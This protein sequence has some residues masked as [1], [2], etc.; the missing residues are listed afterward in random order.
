MK[1]ISI[2]EKIKKERT[3]TGESQENIGK[4][5]LISQIESGQISN[6]KKETLIEIATNL[7]ISFDELIDGTNWI[8]PNQVSASNGLVFSQRGLD[9]K[10][11]SKGQIY[12]KRRVFH[13]K[14]EK[15][16]VNNYCPITGEKL[17]Q[18]CD[19]CEREFEKIDQL[20][21]MGCGKSIF[22]H[23]AIDEE[24]LDILDEINSNI[25]ITNTEAVNYTKVI[26]NIIKRL[27]IFQRL[28]DEAQYPFIEKQ[29]FSNDI[30]ENLSK[31]ESVK[32][33]E[34][35]K[36]KKNSIF[37]QYDVITQDYYDNFISEN[38]YSFKG[39][40]GIDIN[41][42]IN[43]FIEETIVWECFWWFEEYIKTNIS[44]ANGIIEQIKTKTLMSE[45]TISGEN[46][47]E[48]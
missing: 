29:L 17:L 2:G 39:K 33:F 11:T 43:T 15:G 36:I 45:N 5:S 26:R 19:E 37:L 18:G 10:I 24:I 22:K 21:C 30:I 48:E 46:T 4:Q 1:S 16:E 31:Y 7:K 25:N 8:N 23:I 41:G 3:K 34:S 14:N 38:E 20:Y 42:G 47:N 35:I 32:E 9:V 40:D 6:P 27:S 12:Y 28:D 13:Q 44:L